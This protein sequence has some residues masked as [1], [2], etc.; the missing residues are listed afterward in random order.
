MTKT[1]LVKAMYLISKSYP[2][3]QAHQDPE[4][5]GMWYDVFK[6]EDELVFQTAIKRLITTFEYQAPNIAN[7]NKVLAELK[8][9]NKIEAGDVFNEITK[10]VRSYGFYRLEEGYNSLSQIAKDTVDAL[11]GFRTVCLSE[12][13]MVDRSH[14][15]KIAQTYIDRSKSENLLTNSMKKEQLEAKEK[16]KQLTQ[17][18]GN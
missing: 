2:K 9:V 3:F 18:I 12:T 5:I 7:I 13:V 14:A 4:L 8:D 16:I 1:T 15:L 11:G 6:D 17:G 10:A